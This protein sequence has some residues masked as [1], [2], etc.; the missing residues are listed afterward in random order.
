MKT[1]LITGCSSGFGVAAVHRFAKA[2]W[3]VIATMRNLKD[4]PRFPVNV[5]TTRL[6][7]QDS[8]SSGAA[9]RD[10]IEHFGAIDAVV[11]N[12]GFGL[13]GPFETTPSEKVLEQF[14]VNVFGL[15]DVVR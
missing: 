12:A 6:D 14:D 3:N 1:V 13:Y 11:N 10:G 7:V 9:V 5:F 2:D 8:D 4:A 15:M